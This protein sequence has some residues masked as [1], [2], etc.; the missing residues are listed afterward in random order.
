MSARTYKL[1]LDQAL[2]L[3]SEQTTAAKEWRAVAI[4]RLTL[5]ADV[6]AVLGSQIEVLMKIG[7][8]FGVDPSDPGIPST[9]AGGYSGEEIMRA[10]IKRINAISAFTANLTQEATDLQATLNSALT[11]ALEGQAIGRPTEDIS[12]SNLS[13][14]KERSTSPL[15]DV[16]DSIEN[17]PSGEN[18]LS[19]ERETVFYG[20]EE[21]ALVLRANKVAGLFK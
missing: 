7:T 18:D 10:S 19:L 13:Q 1:Q 20:G 12:L 15:T 6:D 11:I 4:N 9:A 3:L 5:L 14:E 16:Y 21:T 17:M 8:I 2:K